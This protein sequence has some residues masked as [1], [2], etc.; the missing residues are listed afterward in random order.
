M[1]RYVLLDAGSMHRYAMIDN[2]EGPN[3]V[4]HIKIEKIS[5][6]RAEEPIMWSGPKAMV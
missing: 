3:N 6:V 2:I 1:A 4:L 5:G